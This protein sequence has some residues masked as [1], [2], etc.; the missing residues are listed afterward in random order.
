MRSW[1][2]RRTKWPSTTVAASYP[3][4]PAARATASATRPNHATGTASAPTGLVQ[5]LVIGIEDQPTATP[6]GLRHHELRL[7][8]AREVGDAVLAEVICGDVG[9]HPDV[10]SSDGQATAQDPTARGLQN[11]GIDPPI[12]EHQPR[13]LRTGVVPLRDALTLDEYAVGTAP[14]RGPVHPP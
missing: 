13:A 10:G 8:E 2:R 3:D 9:D 12:P 5:H 11:R 6:D 7:R 1:P 14:A 4:A